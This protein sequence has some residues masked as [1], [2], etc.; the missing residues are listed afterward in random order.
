MPP[1]P[2]SLAR[3]TKFMSVLSAMDSRSELFEIAKSTAIAWLG[4]HKG[5]L[6]RLGWGKTE[7]V[8]YALVFA[9]SVGLKAIPPIQ[10]KTLGKMGLQGCPG[11]TVE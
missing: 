5:H 3:A 2:L 8:Q 6:K 4:F 1:Q 9:H 11:L 7:L 10:K